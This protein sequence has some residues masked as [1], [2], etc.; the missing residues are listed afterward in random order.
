MILLSHE[1]L[2]GTLARHP[3][4]RHRGNALE[5]LFQC[6]DFAAAIRFINE[7]AA[8]AESMRHHPD[9]VIAWNRVTVTLSSHDVGGITE[10]DLTLATAIDRLY[11][12]RH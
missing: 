3:E 12:R 1:Q 7:I 10:R 11:D 6:A 8:A 9:L 2:K 5:R 4:W